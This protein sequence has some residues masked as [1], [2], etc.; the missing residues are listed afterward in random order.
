[1][2]AAQQTQ[3]VRAQASRFLEQCAERFD[4]IFLDPP[5][6]LA[7]RLIDLRLLPPL[8]HENALVYW[9]AGEKLADESGWR[10]I[11]Y[12]RAGAVHAH[13]MCQSSD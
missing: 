1:M 11:K 6:S 9:E 4:I 7:N 8:L 10:V 5:Y 12:L 13:L 2:L 3:V